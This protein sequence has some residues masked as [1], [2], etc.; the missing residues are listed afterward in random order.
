MQCYLSEE[1]LQ[2]SFIQDDDLIFIKN[3]PGTFW[4]HNVPRDRLS[5]EWSAV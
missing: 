5:L 2:S 4:I 3:F 1:N